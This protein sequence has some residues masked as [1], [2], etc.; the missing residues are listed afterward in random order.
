MPEAA[1][2]RRTR[3]ARSIVRMS[4]PSKLRKLNHHG[5]APS[6]GLLVASQQPARMPGPWGNNKNQVRA[7]DL[8]FA[9]HHSA[10]DIAGKVARC[11][12]YSQ[13]KCSLFLKHARM[14]T[15]GWYCLCGEAFVDRDL[16]VGR[17]VVCNIIVDQLYLEQEGLA[18]TEKMAEDVRMEDFH[19]V[20]PRISIGC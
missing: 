10:Y 3:F 14:V 15:K 12:G 16:E 20:V 8:V 19:M 1:W 11:N 9:V 6:T 18:A 13:G 7:T 4:P 17:R 5:S 2:H